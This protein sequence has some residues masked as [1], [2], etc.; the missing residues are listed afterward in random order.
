LHDD[1]RHS[2]FHRVVNQLI[3]VALSG[4][5]SAIHRYYHSMIFIIT[6][7]AVS[8][9]R[10]SARKKEALYWSVARFE[11]GCLL[12]TRALT[13]HVS[14]RPLTKMNQHLRL[15]KK[16]RT[17][18]TKTR[19]PIPV[20][21]LPPQNL[22]YRFKIR[23]LLFSSNAMSSACIFALSRSKEIVA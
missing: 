15:K 18:P 14:C 9:C 23:K 13:E 12:L 17:K 4:Q 21:G 7:L 16:R 10:A 19:E 6:P 1:F 22:G 5:D 20:N 11:T 8:Q 3:G 2:V